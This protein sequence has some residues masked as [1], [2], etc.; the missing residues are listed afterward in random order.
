MGTYREG[1]KSQGAANKSV[2][3]IVLA[4]LAAKGFTKGTIADRTMAYFRSVG[5]VVRVIGNTNWKYESTVAQDAASVPLP[6]TAT[7]GDWIVVV[8]TQV[9]ATSSIGAAPVGFSTLLAPT[10]TVATNTSSTVAIYAKKYTAGD[11]S[12]SATISPSVVNASS[13]WSLSSFIVRGAD[14]T[15]LLEAG[16]TV[17]DG[18]NTDTITA[19]SITSVTGKRGFALF[20]GR[21][22]TNI[23]V[24]DGSWSTPDGGAK[25]AE[26]NMNSNSSNANLMT[27]SLDLVPGVPSGAKRS[28]ATITGA[29]SVFNGGMGVS[30]AFKPGAGT[31]ANYRGK[32]DYFKRLLNLKPDDLIDPSRLV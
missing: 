25:M 3:D 26:V 2:A 24:T 22:S 30:M 16:P 29:V 27:A 17:Q 14:Q 21:T 1:I 8:A 5:G 32:S 4:A 12:A 31:D 19:P 9:T 13:R 20:Y 28:S 23:L 11:E 6:T 18:G 15:T 7:T 10:A